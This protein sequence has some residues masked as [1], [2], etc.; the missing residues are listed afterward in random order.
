MRALMHDGGSRT[1]TAAMV[2]SPVIVDPGPMIDDR[3]HDHIRANRRG[4]HAVKHLIRVLGSQ[5]RLDPLPILMS[6]MATSPS[7]FQSILDA[8]LDD[9]HKH[10]GIDLT[11]HPSAA[12]LQNCHSPDD[13]IQLLLERETSFKDYREK[14]RKLIDC[15]RPVVNVI[16]A[17]SSILGERAG[18]VSD[19]HQILLTSPYVYR[20]LQVPFQPTKVIFTGIDI[21]LSVRIILQLS[22]LC[23]ISN[24]FISESYQHQCKLRCPWRS[25][26]MCWEYPQT[27]PYLYRKDPVIPCD[28]RYH[29]KNHD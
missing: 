3:S 4:N 10:T 7:N 29:G 23:A 19:H 14:Y 1:E 12:H 25:L 22:C 21:L 11:K 20:S 6:S 16:H 13:V 27:P 9:Y 18:L 28:V 15:L 5:P 17:L 26:W 8:A 2:G 24:H